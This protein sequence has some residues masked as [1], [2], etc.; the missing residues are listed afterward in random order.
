MH[1]FNSCD[2]DSSTPKGLE[3]RHR[4]CH[5][6]NR[7][8][9]L[10]DEVVEVSVLAHQNVNTGVSLDAF[11]GVRAGAALVDGDLLWHIVQVDNALQKAPGCCLIP[12]GSQ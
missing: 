12:F 5:F 2:Q 4:L 8:V 10:L 7:P 11:N 6:F 9:V 3:S 1:G